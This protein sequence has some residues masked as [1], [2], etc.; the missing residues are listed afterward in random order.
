MA[1]ASIN[2]GVSNLLQTLSNFNSPVLSSP[3]V[4]S[5]LE[6]ASPSD[7][8]QLSAEA[9][10][11]EGVDA[12]FGIG[13]AG[14]SDSGTDLSSALASLEDPTTASGNSTTSAPSSSTSSSTAASLT[15]SLAAQLA[16]YQAAVQSDETQ[17]L[18]G[19]GT[20]SSLTGSL[21]DLSG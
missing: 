11:L 13:A 10:Q 17:A 9:T 14:S 18:L 12:M 19:G 20:N 8:V 5:A 15:T 7:I 21:F 3:A 4:V 1:S 16:N 6:K 2:P